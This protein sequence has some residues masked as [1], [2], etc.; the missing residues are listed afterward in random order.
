MACGG[1]NFM[2]PETEWLTLGQQNFGI[3]E[4]RTHTVVNVPVRS[5][6]DLSLQINNPNHFECLAIGHSRC[7]ANNREHCT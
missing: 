3:T 7:P 4:P 1:H 2:G 5:V 6:T